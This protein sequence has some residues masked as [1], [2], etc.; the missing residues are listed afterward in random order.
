M[1]T[2]L[3]AT[4]TPS[5]GSAGSAEK[6]LS[7]APGVVAAKNPSIRKRLFALGILGRA[8]T[9]ATLGCVSETTE[10]TDRADHVRTPP[11]QP[12]TDRGRH[13]HRLGHEREPVAFLFRRLLSRSL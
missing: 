4:G 3:K 11:G 12:N 10:A 7:Q 5:G 9:G 2:R 1:A 8:L 13:G 6:A